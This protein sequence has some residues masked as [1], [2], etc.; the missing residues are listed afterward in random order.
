MLDT[1]NL[2]QWSEVSV[3]QQTSY[4]FADGINVPPKH[5]KRIRFLKIIS[6]MYAF[7]R[8]QIG[9]S[10]SILNKEK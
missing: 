8:F 10:L 6:G 2:S 9:S 7:D 4:A 5:A 3:E 1:V